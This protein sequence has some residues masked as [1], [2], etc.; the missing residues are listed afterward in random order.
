MSLLYL[1]Y[2]ISELG[3]V[4]DH[5]I[6]EVER[7]LFISNYMEAVVVFSALVKLLVDAVKLLALG[8]REVGCVL[9]H[10]ALLLHQPFYVWQQILVADALG[11]IGIHAVHVGDALEGS[12]L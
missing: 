4:D 7:Y 3:I 1:L 9:L 6:I 5:A 8:S 10:L 12:L 2:Y 11:S